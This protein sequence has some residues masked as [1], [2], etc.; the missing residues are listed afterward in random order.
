MPPPDIPDF[1]DS[2][3]GRWIQPQHLGPQGLAE[4]RGRYRTGVDRFTVI[5]DLLIPDRL[6]RIRGVLQEEGVME[7]AYKLR[8][9]ENWVTRE[10]YEAAPDG[11]RFIHELIY[12]RPNPGREMSPAVLADARLR[13]ELASAPFAEWLSAVVGVPAG[14]VEHVNLK[15]LRRH[16]ILRWHSDASAGRT[17]CMILYLH[18][19][20][21]PDYGGRL[22]MRRQDGGV[23]EIEPLFNRLVV[24]DPHAGTVHAVEPLSD[25]AGEWERFNYSIWFHRPDTAD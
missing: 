23:E 20:W 17:L 9:S 21:R 25:A 18:E 14:E 2:T 6:A 22:L 12:R 16:H 7:A 3:L 8:G 19:G 11:D 15:S 1:R 4:H 13:L 5:D 10:Q 24:F